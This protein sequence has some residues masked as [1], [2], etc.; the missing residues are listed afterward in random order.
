[1]SSIFWSQPFIPIIKKLTPKL[2]KIFTEVPSKI[3]KS[4][5]TVAEFTIIRRLFLGR[6]LNRHGLLLRLARHL[7]SAGSLDLLA[8]RLSLVAG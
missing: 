4:L 7:A 2:D 8:A 6:R 3:D 5:E 1:M